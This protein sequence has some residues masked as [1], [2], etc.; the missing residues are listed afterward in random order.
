MWHIQS[1]PGENIKLCCCQLI[2]SRLALSG[3]WRGRA[4]VGGTRNTKGAIETN[5][6][7]SKSW[8]FL[9]RHN[10]SW[11]N[12]AQEIGQEKS[13]HMHKV[14]KNGQK[15]YELSVKNTNL[16]ILWKVS[17]I[18]CRCTTMICWHLESLTNCDLA[19]TGGEIQRGITIQYPNLN[20]FIHWSNEELYIYS[21]CHL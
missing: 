17:K 9:R 5:C 14:G 20:E 19:I 12:F 18:V 13:T 15:A 3:S 11:D 6:R 2:Q 8:F 7:H 1:F 21:C 16:N 10:F 4:G